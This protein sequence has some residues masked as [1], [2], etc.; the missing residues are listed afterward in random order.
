MMLTV[1]TTETQTHLRTSFL[2]LPKWQAWVYCSVLELHGDLE[3]S[4]CSGW[5][6]GR[7]LRVP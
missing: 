1:R 4:L 5:F 6:L 7:Y 3:M 2:L